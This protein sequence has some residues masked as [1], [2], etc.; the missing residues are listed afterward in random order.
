MSKQNYFLNEKEEQVM[1]TL[2]NSDK[3]LSATDIANIID[4]EW[5]HKSIQNVIKKLYSNGLI[6][7]AL[8]AKVSK[9][10][11][12]YFVTKIT[13]EDYAEMQLSRI[14]DNKSALSLI[15]RLV[16]KQTDSSEL[17]DKLQNILNEYE[18]E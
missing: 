9:T 5:A 4:T 7:I 13:K 12:R 11:G 2:W 6:E 18:E 8:I 15:L 1:L 14:Y 16:N 10:Y 17:S 3:P